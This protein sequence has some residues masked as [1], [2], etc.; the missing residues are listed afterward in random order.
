MQRTRK[1]RGFGLDSYISGLKS[2]QMQRWMPES[3]RYEQEDRE[4][5]E[6]R[7]G[8]R[9]LGYK[10]EEKSRENEEKKREGRR[11]GLTEEKAKRKAAADLHKNT[12]IKRCITPV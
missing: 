7:E 9:C 8:A 4:T 3:G 1:E 5:R 10:R 6:E 12:V 2:Q 11:P